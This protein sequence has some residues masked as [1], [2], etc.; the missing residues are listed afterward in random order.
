MKDRAKK[1][2]DAFID[3]LGQDPQAIETWNG[4]FDRDSWTKITTAALHAATLADLSYQFD[5]QPPEIQIAAKEH[6]DRYGRSEYLTLDV[7]GIIDN[8]SAPKVVVEHENACSPS[9]IRYC[10]WKLL[11]VQADLRVLVAYVDPDRVH[12]TCKKSRKALRK[13]LKD[14]L[15]QHPDTRVLMITGKWQKDPAGPGG[16]KDVFDAGL[17]HASEGKVRDVGL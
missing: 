14:V 15:I 5:S 10:L 6:P 1:F 8:W 7:M 9:K 13:E 4:P 12:E 2:F 17:V 16:W 3:A 11:V